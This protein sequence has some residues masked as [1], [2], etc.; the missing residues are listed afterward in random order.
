MRIA[1]CFYGLVG[2]VNDKNGIGKSLD[3]KNGFEYFDKNILSANDSE[4]VF[5]HS[6][7][8]HEMIRCKLFNSQK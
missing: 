5:I 3:P 4:D 8:D 1:I 6:W 2:S 7:Y